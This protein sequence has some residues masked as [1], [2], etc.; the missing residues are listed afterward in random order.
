MKKALT[1]D[2]VLLVPQYSDIRSRAE[3]NLKTDFGKGILINMP[4]ISSPMDTVSEADM[5]YNLGKLGGLSIIHRY[6]TIEEQ[7]AMVASISKDVQVG[8]AVGIVGDYIER[9]MS[10][11]FAGAEVICIDVAHGHHILM[12]EA[13]A[14]L[15]KR[16]GESI[17]IMAGNVA[18]LEGYNDLADWGADSIRCNIGGGCFVAGTL[19]RTTEGD[20][21]I[22]EVSVGDSVLTHTGNVRKVVDTLSFDRD[23]EIAIVNGIEATL[24]HEFYV[25]DKD[26]AHLVNDSNIGDFAYWIE[27]SHLDK[28][29]HLLVE[30]E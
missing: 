30:V 2:D 27:A 10:A 19:V 5:A 25:V 11:A 21:P 9:A 17:H 16:M 29:R 26:K 14:A 8:V 18:T 4:I 6:N 23:E 7:S 3:V 1:Y 22:E 15:R 13:L 12:K 28:N 20:K 24:N